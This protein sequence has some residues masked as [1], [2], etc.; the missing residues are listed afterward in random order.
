MPSA[1]FTFQYVHLPPNLQP[2]WLLLATH[3]TAQPRPVPAPCLTTYGA[4]LRWILSMYDT[5]T[6]WDKCRAVLFW[7]A[8]ERLGG[9][10]HVCFGFFDID[11][12]Y[13]TWD[14]SSIRNAPAQSMRVL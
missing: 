4:S 2:R 3:S 8:P 1:L 12:V 7:T 9:S 11:A 13:V 6:P 5:Y 14:G 10:M